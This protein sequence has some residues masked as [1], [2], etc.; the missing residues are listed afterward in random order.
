[1]PEDDEITATI[2]LDH[3]AVESPSALEVV[4]QETNETE[5]FVKAH[6]FARTAVPQSKQIDEKTSEFGQRAVSPPYNPLLWAQLLE[7]STRLQS[8]VHAMAENTVGLGWRVLPIKKVNEKTPPEVRAQ[9][10][11]E[12]ALLEN[13]FNYP[14]EEMPFTEI[15][16]LV[17]ID[18]EATGNGFLEV[19][20]DLG[21]A[22]S[23]FFHVA[24]HT[25]RVDR[26]G[27][28]IQR[29]DGRTRYFKAFGDPRDKHA[30]EGTW[31]EPNALPETES[32]NELIHFKLYTPRDS[33]YGIPRIVCAS[34]AV[35]GNRLAAVR[36]AA[37]FENDAV[38]RLAFLISGGHL[39][40]TSAKN[41][42]DFLQSDAKGPSNAHRVMVVEAEGKKVAIGGKQDPVKIA[43]EK[44][45]VG[46][47]DDASF[48]DYRKA[49]DEEIREAFRIGSV[50]LGT[51]E[52]NNR[53]VAY[54]SRKITIEQVFKPEQI[55]KEYVINHKIVRSL[56][57]KL[58]RFEFLR[59][60][61]DDPVDTAPADGVHARFGG[62]TPND[63]RQERGLEPYPAELG[64]G[65]LP[66]DLARIKYQAEV[67]GKTAENTSGV[68]LAASLME[69][70]GKLAAEIQAQR[71]VED[72][73]LA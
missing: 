30:T 33:F 29:R 64:F 56:G 45:T 18:E 53:A 61:S 55:R 17:K 35:T 49:N 70:R 23:S 31:H 71:F 66:F 20:R 14:N 10:E 42:K 25:I 58:V 38:P 12:T 67:L 54:V 27:G 7:K 59:P 2:Q 15:M 16:R 50:F 48:Q 57:V 11:A 34:P 41:I 52:G 4:E 37:F 19:V 3:D 21:G 62:L 47:T 5:E 40:D 69:L 22:P 24:S 6:V 1:V 43:L 44:L 65:D 46:E 68:S 8:C 60:R 36:N 32:A 63:I 9:I 28:F 51:S 73:D 13:L 26:Q 39:T 72:E